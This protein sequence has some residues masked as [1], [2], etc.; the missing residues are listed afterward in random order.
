MQPLSQHLSNNIA[1]SSAHA[2]IGG[3]KGQ[4]EDSVGYYSP[5]DNL[6]V[7]KGACGI[8][9]DGVSSAE[10]GAQAAQ[11]CVTEFI[12]DYFDTPDIWTVKKSAQ[13]VLSS[14]NRT[15]YSRSNEYL[16]SRGWVCT[17]SAIVIKSHTAHL[18]HIGDSR[19]YRIRGDR[20]EC[21]TQDHITLQSKTNSCL[22]RAMGMDV[23][24]DLDYRALAIEAQ[25]LYLL[26]TD[27]VHDSLE[28]QTIQRI[29]QENKDLPACCEQL[30]KSA[31]DAGSSDNISC[32]LI[33]VDHLCRDSM[34]DLTDKLTKLPFP[35]P[36]EVGMKLDGFLVEEEI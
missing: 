17:L 34:N 7:T 26:T 16:D 3:R 8:I 11:F 24:L 5:A 36:L 14:I 18:F 9:A 35:P 15:L 32:Q 6:Q 4:N 12:K 29:I 31:Y 30:I 20:M 28:P 22:S 2:S 25:D 23:H 13:K 10:A 21:L 33:R 19:I 27:G 1:L